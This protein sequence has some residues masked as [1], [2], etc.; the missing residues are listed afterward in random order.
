M[1]TDVSKVIE[2]ALHNF[3]IGFQGVLH[4]LRNTADNKCDLRTSNGGILKATNNVAIDM[5]IIKRSTD[6]CWERDAFNHGCRNWLSLIYMGF[7]ED[8][9]DVFLL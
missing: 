5:V 7:V 6:I 8:L 3:S 4:E 1:I 2:D 9:I